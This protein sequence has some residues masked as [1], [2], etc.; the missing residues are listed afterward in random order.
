[1]S[2]NY[3]Q[4]ELV[5]DSISIVNP[6]KESVDILNLTTNITI[7]EAINTPFISGRISV[8]DGLEIDNIYKLMG[9]ESL[10]I[11][12]RQREGVDEELSLPQFSI[13]KTFR[14]YRIIFIFIFVQKNRSF[15]FKK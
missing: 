14:I 3:Q 7:F 4:G 1:M 15:I 12:V 2:N 8:I 11:K 9:Q 5:V 6:E 10:T 13:D